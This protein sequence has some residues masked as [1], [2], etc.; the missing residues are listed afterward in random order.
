MSSENSDGFVEI[1]KEQMKF[2]FDEELKNYD[3]L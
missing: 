2:T 1:K 3:K